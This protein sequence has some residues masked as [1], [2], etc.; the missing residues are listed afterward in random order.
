MPVL[1][2]QSLDFLLHNSI[3]SH[4]LAQGN[5]ITENINSR[6]DNT[7]ALFWTDAPSSRR[8]FYSERMKCWNDRK[9][10]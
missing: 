6:I 4:R 3:S 10:M 5:T 2:I 1:N 9:I 8:F 7:V